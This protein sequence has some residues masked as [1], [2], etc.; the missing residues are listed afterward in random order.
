[1]HVVH[2]RGLVLRLDASRFQAVCYDPF[3][4]LLNI[5]HQTGLQALQGSQNP[6]QPLNLVVKMFAM[7]MQS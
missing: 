4:L 3:A 5:N 2:L 7:R 1:M 6:Q